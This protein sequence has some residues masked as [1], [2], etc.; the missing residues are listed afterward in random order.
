MSWKDGKAW[1]FNMS[2][3]MLVVYKNRIGKS[4]GARNLPNESR[5]KRTEKILSKTWDHTKG[6]ENF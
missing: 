3:Q 2:Q 4:M 5:Q 6:I 1:I